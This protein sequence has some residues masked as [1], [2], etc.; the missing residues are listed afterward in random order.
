MHWVVA[1]ALAAA[2]ALHQVTGASRL[3]RGLRP[4][5]GAR[6]AAASSTRSAAP[7]GTSSTRR[8]RPAATVWPGKPDAYHVVQAL[9][10]PRLPPAPTIVPALARGLLDTPAKEAPAAPDR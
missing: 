3:R 7:G 2:A 8:N 4:H 6:H 9:L 10:L 1:E 5:L